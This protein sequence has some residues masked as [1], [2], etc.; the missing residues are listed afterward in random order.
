MDTG[1]KDPEDKGKDVKSPVSKDVEPGTAQDKIDQRLKEI[2][3]VD[4]GA[5]KPPPVETQPPTQPESREQATQITKEDISGYLNA[6]SEDTLPEAMFIGDNEVDLK[7]FAKDYPDQ[8]S[9]VKI[10]SSV[11]AQKMVDKALSDNQYVKASDMQERFDH[12]D[13]TINGFSW[14]EVVKEKHPDALQT[15]ESPEFQGWFDKL[16]A[17]MQ[18]FGTES[19]DPQ[20][21]VLLLDLY[22]ESQTKDQAKGHDDK[23]EKTKK[24]IDSLHKGTMRTKQNV[25]EASS[26]NDKD[27]AEAAFLAVDSKALL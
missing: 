5:E 19:A 8:W 26:D 1:G 2:D 13:R 22:A 24:N 21:A 18:Q 16:P 17:K 9:A 12:Y 11:V 14:W 3:P 27:D 7:T 6:M 23:L 10:V 4:E 25:I 15:K 20:D